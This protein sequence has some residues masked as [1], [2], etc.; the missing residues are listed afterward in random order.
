MSSDNDHGLTSRAWFRPAVGLW[1]GML[2]GAGTLGVLYVTPPA[3]R[4]GLFQQAGLSGLHRFFEP[5]VGMAGFAAVAIVA[6]LL[7]LLFGLVVARRLARSSD[8]EEWDEWEE[9]ELIEEDAEPEDHGRKRMFSARD[10]IGEEGIAITETAVEIDEAEDV[11]AA[12]EPEVITAPA[13]KPFVEAPAEPPEVVPD[14]APRHESLADLSLDQLT[15]RLGAALQASKSGPKAPQAPLQEDDPD[16]V[17]SF[18]R[19]EASRRDGEDVPQGD[20]PQAALRSAL[21]KLGRVGKPD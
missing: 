14:T 20:D 13:P 12:E 9:P 21:D 10:D 16:H 8:E 6:G 5:P 17:I 19:R 11:D 2:I 7:G 15:R 1:F 3:T 18:L 4:D